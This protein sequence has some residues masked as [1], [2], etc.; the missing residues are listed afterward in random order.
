MFYQGTIRFVHELEGTKSEGDYA[1]LVVDE[2]SRYRLYRAGSPAADSEFLRPF[3]D[4][5]VIVEG[6]AEDEET[7][8]ITTINNE[9][10]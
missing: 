3:E 7:M 2:K 5:E 10:V 9:E 4:Q 6:V 1:Y 8:C